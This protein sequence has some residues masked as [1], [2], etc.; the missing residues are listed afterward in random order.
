[1]LHVVN[2]SQSEFQAFKGNLFVK[3]S[4]KVDIKKDVVMLQETSDEDQKPTGVQSFFT[5][6]KLI[7]PNR[8]NGIKKGYVIADLKRIKDPFKELLKEQG[9]EVT[10]ENV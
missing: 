4:K 9:E 2:I 1:M 6:T 7:E 5:I 10:A 3:A 8:S